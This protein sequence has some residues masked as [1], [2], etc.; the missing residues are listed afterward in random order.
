MI[1]CSLSQ[2]WIISAGNEGV[3]QNSLPQMLKSFSSPSRLY[4]LNNVNNDESSR[5]IL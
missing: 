2:I 1:Y 4:L 5:Q 3:E